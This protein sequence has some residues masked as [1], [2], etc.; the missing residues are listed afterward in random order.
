VVYGDFDF[1]GSDGGAEEI[2][3]KS[4]YFASGESQLFKLKRSGHNMMW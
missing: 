2:V 1:M 3:K 4:K